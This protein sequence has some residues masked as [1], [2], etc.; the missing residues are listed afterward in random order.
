M[1]RTRLTKE[2]LIDKYRRTH[3]ESHNWHE[4]AVKVFPANGATHA[5]RVLDPFRPYITNAKGSKIWDV[6]GNEYI[7]YVMGHG[8]LILG[9]SHPDVMNAL[10]EQIA[11]GVHFSSNQELEVEWAELIKQ[12]MPV[13][14]RI[15]LCACG[16]EANVMAIRLARIFTGRRKILR[17]EGN[18]HGWVDVVA[19]KES[20]GVHQAETTI[21]PMNDLDKAEAELAKEEYAI[22]MT[23]G[24]GAQMAGRVPWDTGFIH[25][26]SSLARKYGTLWH[27]DEVVTSF[28]D[29]RGGW[30]ELIGVKPDLTSIGKCAG[31][32]LPI[33]ATLGRADIM[34]ALSP[35]LPLE[36]RIR[37][38]GTWNANPL[39]CAAGSAACQL[40]LDGVPQ[41]KAHELGAYL[42]D[43]GNKVLKERNYDCRLYGRTIIHIYFGQIEYEPSDISLPPSRDVK[44][45]MDPSVTPMRTYLSLHLLQRGIATYGARFF[46]LS[47]AH[48]K[49]EIDQTIEAL[50]NSLDDMSAEST[51][52]KA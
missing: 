46:V 39:L 17:F 47:E 22:V 42:R 7:D 12:M 25:A 50:V 35:E 44:K 23:E 9:H 26:L 48:T 30:Q 45:I 5:E 52:G 3:L 4:R 11:K 28:R 15:E 18:Y 1:R 49:E 32:G 16:Q 19:S 31:G 10:Q 27:I 6:D 2:S 20:V 43:K 40:Y 14:E 33:G 13:A 36:Q 8:S 24:G 21:I 38:A 41:K 34:K 29:S 51:M 37:H